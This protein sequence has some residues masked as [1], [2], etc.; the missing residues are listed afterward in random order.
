MQTAFAEVNA[1]R[2][3]GVGRTGRKQGRME[4]LA[5]TP[6]TA[7]VIVVALLVVVAIVWMVNAQR[8]SRSLRDRFGPEYDR[9]LNERGRRH[10]EKELDRRARRVAELPIRP[11][12]E[13]ERDRYA[14]LWRAEQARFVDDP[15]GAVNE[16]D[17]LVEEVM[18]RR[19]YPIGD[20]EQRAAD[21]SVD[22]PVVVENYRAAHHIA[23]RLERGQAATEDLRQAMVHYRT[24]F[25]DLLEEHIVPAHDVPYLRRT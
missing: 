5:M 13:G 4:E 19:G 2:V 9:E 10:A 1:R 20:F 23:T 7:F 21:I 12:P 22:H 24:L 18:R 3:G 15:R 17:R 8:H 16:A 25:E 11:L 6:T 14:E